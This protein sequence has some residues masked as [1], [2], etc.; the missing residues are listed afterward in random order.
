MS[1]SLSPRPGETA[2]TA[3]ELT[4]EAGPLARDPL[5]GE[6]F[7][8][9]S[10]DNGVAGGGA[11]PSTLGKPSTSY[12]GSVGVSV[13]TMPAA[14]ASRRCSPWAVKQ[15]PVV[16]ME[17]VQALRQLVSPLAS[18]VGSKLRPW[19]HFVALRRPAPGTQ[20]RARIEQNLAHYQANYLLVSAVLLVLTLLTH[21]RGAIA[22]VLVT[23]GWAAYARGGGMEP[24]WTPQFGGTDVT[25]SHRLMLLGASSIALLFMAAGEML[26][27]FAGISAA[28]AIGHASL[29][30]GAAAVGDCDY[31]SVV[32]E[33]I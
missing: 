23:L 12:E 18:T 13:S 6:L 14:S 21:T 32:N 9:L 1:S 17:Y 5:A 28:L 29:H 24:T 8:G 27:M 10:V 30:P 25:S 33:E 4:V 22:A 31:T 20:W 2:A 19:R 3:T 16:V 26:M 15:L 11:A 7:A